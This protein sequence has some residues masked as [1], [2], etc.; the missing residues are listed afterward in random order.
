LTF[1]RRQIAAATI[2]PQP[3]NVVIILGKNCRIASIFV[4]LQIHQK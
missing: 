4:E 3:K 1:R 2:H